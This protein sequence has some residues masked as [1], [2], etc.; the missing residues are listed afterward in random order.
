MNLSG[1]FPRLKFNNEEPVYGTQPTGS[2]YSNYWSKYVELLYNPY[3]RLIEA[4]GIIPLAIYSQ[5]NLND[6][7]E[8]RGNYYHLRAIN[9]YSVKTG[10]CNLQL[11]G[12]IIADTFGFASENTPTTT[13][14]T[15]STT[16]TSTSTTSTSTPM[17]I[18]S[19]GDNATP[20][21]FIVLLT[22]R[23]PLIP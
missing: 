1:K 18:A 22:I 23:Y 3:T 14:T 8:W 4:N 19:G 20:E 17:R 2:L 11:L 6:I 7:I 15:T 10:E 16:T 21:F 9:N 12:P 5:L 13:T